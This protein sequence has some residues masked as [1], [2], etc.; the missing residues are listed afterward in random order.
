[1]SRLLEAIAVPFL[2]LRLWIE[3]HAV[4]LATLLVVAAIIAML[5]EMAYCV[6]GT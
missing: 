6:G 5:V 1:M 2:H 4:G 3:E